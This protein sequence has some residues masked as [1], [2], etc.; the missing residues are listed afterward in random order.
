M[1]RV[2]PPR[3]VVTGECA[4]PESRIIVE[5]GCP[6]GPAQ[7]ALAEPWGT[8]LL[9]ARAGFG[10][11][12]FGAFLVL[13]ASPVS[14]VAR[15]LATPRMLTPRAGF[16]GWRSLN[17]NLSASGAL[18]RQQAPPVPSFSQGAATER[19][20]LSTHTPSFT[21]LTRSAASPSW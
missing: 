13:T 5:C 2:G 19:D 9:F 16:D 17:R 14:G 20:C 11:L 15:R 8:A 21:C 12:D 7:F 4:R 1:G 3:T 10:Q 6:V 18:C